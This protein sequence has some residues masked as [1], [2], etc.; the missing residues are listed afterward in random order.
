[1]DRERVVA[2]LSGGV[3]SSVAA[4][5]L[6]E[7]GC[8]VVGVFLRSGATGAPAGERQGCCSVEDAL[9]ARR[10][11]DRLGIPFYALNMEREFGRLIDRFAADY[12]AGRTPNPCVLC[13]RW[14]KFGHVLRF[15]DQVGAAA[16]ASGHYARVAPEAGRVALRRARDRRKDQSYVLAVL[17]QAQLARV[18][19]PLGALTKEEVRAMARARGLLRVADKPDS[20]ELCFVA[21]DYR[22]LLRERLPADAPA[23]APG[24]VRDTAG[25]L[26]GTHAGTAGYTVGQRRGLGIGGAGAPL[27][28]VR[29]EPA[30][31]L[32]VVGGAADLGAGGLL[33][34]EATWVGRRLGPGEQARGRAQLRAHG[35]AHPVTVTCTGPDAFEATF[36]APARAV[37]PGQA[38]V[39]YDEADDA[40]QLAG[41]IRAALPA[42]AGARA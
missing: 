41:W 21:G 13:N 19:F 28:V 2:C 42:V 1:M 5:L 4:A 32:V 6:V 18:R 12:A 35:A 10:V 23:L 8:D 14:L 36:D 33:A 40:V 34:E 9:D 7:A 37:V 30:R 15:A 26:R 31:R 17:E 11:A 16:V 22:D 20:Q 39:V 25:R 3:D 24:E 29:T 27:Y 38:V